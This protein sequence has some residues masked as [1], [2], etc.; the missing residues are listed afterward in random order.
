MDI[1]ITAGTADGVDSV[2]RL[3]ERPGFGGWAREL[4]AR[5]D[6]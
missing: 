1:G 5:V 3:Y 4:L 2:V 6:D